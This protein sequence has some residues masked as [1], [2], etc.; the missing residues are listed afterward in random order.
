MKSRAP[1]AEFYRIA[2]KSGKTLV[3]N[4]RSCDDS[5]KANLAS[6]KDGKVWGVLYCL[7]FIDLG[8]LDACESGYTRE[9]TEVVDSMNEAVSAFVYLSSKLTKDTRPYDWYKELVVEGAKEHKLPSEYI[10]FLETFKS[11]PDLD[12]KRGSK[13]C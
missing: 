6:D 9:L 5:A 8:K 1:S 3:F 13:C 10:R 4:K 12:P 11:K 7:D 2:R